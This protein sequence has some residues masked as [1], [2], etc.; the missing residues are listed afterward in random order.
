MTDM[1]M[2]GNLYGYYQSNDAGSASVILED[3]T[4]FTI[5]DT[6]TKAESKAVIVR[7]FPFSYPHICSYPRRHLSLHHVFP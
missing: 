4:L 1:S 3:G 7:G 6:Y 2:S 5:I